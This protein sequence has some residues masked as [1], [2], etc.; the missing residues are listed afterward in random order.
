MNDEIGTP[1]RTC[2]GCRQR[3]PRDRLI[4][5]VV[6]SGTAC[7]DPQASAPGRGAWLHPDE[8]C[9]AA[10]LKNG[11]FNRAFKTRITSVETINQ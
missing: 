4:R 1:L 7:Y 9:R 6:R 5:F 10:A 2:V 8:T 11:G 3:S